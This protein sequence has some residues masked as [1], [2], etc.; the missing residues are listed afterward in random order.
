MQE[1]T[2]YI[3]IGFNCNISHYLRSNELRHQAFPF[4]WNVTPITTALL[5]IKNKFEGFLNLQNLQ[6]L[7]P[8]KRL[9]FMEDGINL[10]STND[11]ITPVICNRYGIL[12][13]HDFSVAGIDDY[14]EVNNKYIKRIENLMRLIENDK[15]IVFVYHIGNPNDWQLEQYRLADEKF[16]VSSELEIKKI[17]KTLHLKNVKLISLDELRWA[18]MTLAQRFKR[19]FKKCWIQFTNASFGLNKN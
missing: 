11:I 18:R 16:E 9:L 13:P 10:K 4:D 7:P 14:K 2:T 19:I 6:F 3:P 8:V 17:F 12:F 5:L 1:K 15:N